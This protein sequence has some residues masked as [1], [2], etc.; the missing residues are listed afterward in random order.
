MDGGQGHPASPSVGMGPRTKFR[1]GIRRRALGCGRQPKPEI[2][3]AHLWIVRWCTPKKRAASGTL[4][5]SSSL[6]S[7]AIAL[8]INGRAARKSLTGLAGSCWGGGAFGRIQST[9]AFRGAVRLQPGGFSPSAI[10][11]P[12]RSPFLRT[13]QITAASFCP[14]SRGCQCHLDGENRGNNAA[15]TRPCRRLQDQDIQ[16]KLRNDSLSPAREA[17]TRSSRTTSSAR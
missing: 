15:A 1:R 3:S 2:R 7:V 4:T 6:L 13:P 12:A 16:N 14:I 9:E 8:S 17:A 11:F 10:I 5:S